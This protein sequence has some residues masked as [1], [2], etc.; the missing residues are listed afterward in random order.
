VNTIDREPHR[1]E[2]LRHRLDWRLV[3]ALVAVALVRPLSSVA[4]LS[5]ALG[6]P[7]TPLLLTAAISLV[8]IL[9][10]GLGRAREPVLTLV[11]AGLG[12]ALAAVV[13]S[14]VLSPV[15]TG[16]LRGPLA[17]PL[18]IVP[19]FVTNAA[20]GALCGVCALGLRRLR[21]R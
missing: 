3:T 12:Y 7:A 1:P 4:G 17:M 18:A 9:T 11:A 16:E 20:W 14:G 19:L 2:P 6:K 8:W 5:D 21:G 13:L 15:L 10:V